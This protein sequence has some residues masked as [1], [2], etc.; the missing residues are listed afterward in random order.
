MA[1]FIILVVFAGAIFLCIKK[2]SFLIVASNKDYYSVDDLIKNFGGDWYN[3][4]PI[5]YK[6]DDRITNK[7]VVLGDEYI[8]YN[9]HLKYFMHYHYN[10][11]EEV[12][13]DEVKRIISKH[14]RFKNFK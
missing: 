5:V 8:E 1:I 2:K 14:Q 9:P 10:T 11:R 3:S 13:E 7:I 4:F 6:N 12:D